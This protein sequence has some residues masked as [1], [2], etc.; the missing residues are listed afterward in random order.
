MFQQN[1]AAK[2]QEKAQQ[3]NAAQAD[4]TRDFNAEEAQKSRDWSGTQAVDQMAFQERMSST[5][6]QRAM[7]DMRTAGLNPILAYKQGQSSSP[8]GAMGSTSAASGPSASTTAQP[9]H[10]I[11][12]PAVSTAMQAMRLKED[13][14]NLQASREL[15]NATAGKTRAE[16]TSEVLRQPGIPAQVREQLVKAETGELG[17]PHARTVSKVD[18]TE[19]GQR[20]TYAG[21]LADRLGLSPG[22]TARSI[23]GL[24]SQGPAATGFVDNLN[25]RA[26]GTVNPGPT[27]PVNTRWPFR[28]NEFKGNTGSAKGSELWRGY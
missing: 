14:G 22:S 6:Y 28:M 19:A 18:R 8:S 23:F 24:T 4:L 3:F 2:A 13:I 9:M 1:S 20:A 12:T 21:T 27:N 15:T 11:L 10:D 5:A 25:G 26:P 7:Q 17:L 16:T